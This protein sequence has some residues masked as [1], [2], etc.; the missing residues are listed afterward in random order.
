MKALSLIVLLSIPAASLAAG[1]DAA[2]SGAYAG[3]RAALP[4]VSLRAVNACFEREDGADADRLGLPKRFCLDRV[5]TREPANAVT[6]FEE[7]G[8]GLIEGAPASG[9]KHISGGARRA[10]GGW[11]LVV[12]LFSG[13]EAPQ[14]CGRLNHAFAA[15]YFPVDAVGRPLDGPVEVR[16]FL[17]D[18]SWPCAKTAAAV[19]LPYRRLP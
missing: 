9:R 10:D 7:E 5:G 1:G 6:P 4:V 16:G 2:L 14:A 11:D 18:H 12:D 13:P 8:S 15:A 3:I 19:A 17:V